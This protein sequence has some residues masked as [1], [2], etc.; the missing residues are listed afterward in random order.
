MQIGYA[1]FYPTWYNLKCIDIDV[2][3]KSMNFFQ[4]LLCASPTF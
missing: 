4:N 2:A 3:G 1:E